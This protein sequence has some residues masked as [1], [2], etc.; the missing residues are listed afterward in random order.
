MA[1]LFTTSKNVTTKVPFGED[2]RT[3]FYLQFVPGIVVDTITH[4]SVYKGYD[5]SDLINS[6]TAIPHITED[7]KK[8]RLN[9]NEDDRY[10]PLMRGIFEVPAKGDPVL[11]CEIG[12]IKYYLGPLNTQNNPNWNTDNLYSSEPT[13]DNIPSVSETNPIL[14][15]GE[16]LNFQK[17]KL[18]RFAKRSIKK[19][20]GEDAYNETHGDIMLEGRHG[21]SIRVGSRNTN[22]YVFISN[23]RASQ[24]NIQETLFDG[25]LISITEKGSLFDHFG[26]VVETINS[27]TED[28]TEESFQTDGF[29]LSSDTI[30]PDKI[31]RL[32]EALVSSVN[33]DRPSQEEIYQYGNNENQNQMLFSSDRII[34]NTKNDDIYLSSKK[35]IHIGTGRHL[36]ISSNEDLIVESEK[37]FLGNPKT[38]EMESMVLGNTLIEV[39]QETLTVLKEAQGLCTGAPI[40]LVDSTMTP[41]ST[42][43]VQI[44]QKLNNIISNKHFIEQN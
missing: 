7:T 19:L 13:I 23:A 18:N 21:N 44:E 11:L 32:M 40:P 17:I 14:A 2:V 35:D 15:S 1:S 6:I 38:N 20:D 31:N 41:L 27:N 22:P 42:K 9:L 3:P 33:N 43:V 28:G 34:I 26:S 39:L 37:T 12:G 30:E 29:K 4:P 8:R 5:N 16:S 10:F 25:S 36:T 24:Y